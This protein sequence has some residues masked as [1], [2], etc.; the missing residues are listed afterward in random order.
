MKELEVREYLGNKIEFKIIDGEVYANATSFN[1]SIKLANWKRSTGTK[2]LMEALQSSENSGM[3]N[4]HS[5]NKLII[6]SSGANTDNCTWLHESLIL[7]FAQYISVK[8]RVWCQTQITTLLREGT[9]SL[10]PKLPTNYLEAL[11]ALVVSEKEKIKLIE[12]TEEQKPKVEV[13]EQIANSTS[14]Y[15]MK[16]IADLLKI[17]GL[18]RN[19]LIAL[20]KQ[21]EILTKR[22]EPKRSYLEQGYFE[23][24]VSTFSIHKEQ[25]STSTTKVTGKGL[26][27]LTKLLK[28]K[29]ITQSKIG[30]K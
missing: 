25:C 8:L 15:T 7:D 20:L 12:L 3:Q 5:T 4:L 27:W 14:L 26:T 23:V 9:V 17:K 22:G 24:K 16:E 21:K 19:N 28:P 2:D 18:G 6:S 1:E 11:E 10:T 13:F 30:F 29:T